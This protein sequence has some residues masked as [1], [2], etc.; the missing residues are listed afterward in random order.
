MWWYL[1]EGVVEEE[2]EVLASLSQEVGGHVILQLCA[3]HAV[4]A[5]PAP[6][7]P[8]QLIQGL[9]DG[10]TGIQIP[11]VLSGLRFHS[12]ETL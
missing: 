8:V 5:G 11:S 12:N 2:E 1:E 9:D 10:C 3:V 6:L 7:H 4:H